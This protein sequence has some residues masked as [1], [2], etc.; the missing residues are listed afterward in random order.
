[1]WV[2]SEFE[3]GLYF[4]NRDQV[5]IQLLNTLEPTRLPSLSFFFCDDDKAGDEDGDKDDVTTTR[6]KTKISGLKTKGKGFCLDLATEDE[7]WWRW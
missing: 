4:L 7:E 5:Q 3:V 2:R 6:K 1:M